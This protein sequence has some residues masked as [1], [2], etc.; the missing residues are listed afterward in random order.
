L[1]KGIIRNNIPIY[2]DCSIKE[3]VLSGNKT[4]SI[5]CNLEIARSYDKIIVS[6]NKCNSEFIILKNSLN[7]DN[8][9]CR[10]CKQIETS[11]KKYGTESPNQ[12]QEIKEKQHS[13]Q[14][15]ENVS[16]SLKKLFES[17][18]FRENHR[19]RTKEAANTLESK[20][21]RSMNAKILWSNPEYA[22]LVSTKVRKSL[23]NPEVKKKRSEAQK[24][25]YKNPEYKEKM[26]ALAKEK[27]RTNN[28]CRAI[29]KVHTISS[30]QQEIFNMLITIDKNWIMEYFI[31][32]TGYTVD[33]Y[34]KNTNEIMECFG[35]Y[36]HCNP[37]K[38]SSNYYHKHIQLTA[39]EIWK[40]DLIRIINL[41]NLGYKVSILWEDDW[42]NPKKINLV[43]YIF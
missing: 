12:V 29:S 25:L 9:L 17:D 41:Q 6:C 11:L 34:N 27:W 19:L 2:G 3:V 18:D 31:Q 30:F 37:L 20:E 40:K 22:E 21:K 26:I 33:L 15:R 42:R 13:Q 14:M 36:W 10:K 28:N 32:D 35:D 5:I 23:Q 7:L 43:K 8:Q 1:L 16:R 4:T 39:E 24:I 38:F